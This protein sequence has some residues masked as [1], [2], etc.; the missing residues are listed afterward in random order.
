MDDD[1]RLRDPKVLK[2][3]DPLHDAQ[4]LR[5]VAIINSRTVE[6]LGP[7]PPG[8]VPVMPKRRPL[9]LLPQPTAPK[10][11]DDKESAMQKIPL[12]IVAAASLAL[13]ACTTPGPATSPS[14]DME[15]ATP[16]QGARH[17]YPETPI[18]VSGELGPEGDPAI[19]ARMN[20]KPV[21][22]PLR[23]KKHS[24]GPR[25]YDTL[26][27]QVIYDN[28]DFGLS[29]PTKSSASYGPDYLKGWTGSYGAVPNFPAAARVI[30]RSKDGTN[31]EADIDIGQIFSDGLVRHFVPREEISEAPNGEIVV[32]PSV[33][34]EV[35]DR[36][37]RVYMSA[38]VPTKHLQVPG[39]KRSGFRDDLVLV[40][41]YTY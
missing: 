22:W 2:P 6:L 26:Q 28:F 4:L 27:C 3:G 29:E 1:G 35:N 33:L 11:H 34:L 7:L 12:P 36:T 23:F 9:P 10:G 25:C 30:W 15:R 37:I 21:A 24:F 18:L 31:H 16:M 5:D 19:A 32:D 13:A 40:Q 39:N 8:G 41:T 20:Y 38:F 14:A 17:T